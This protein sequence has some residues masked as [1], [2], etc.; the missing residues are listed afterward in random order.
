MITE[1]INEEEQDE[2]NDAVPAVN[3]ED[4]TEVEDIPTEDADED[5]ELWS[6]Q[7]MQDVL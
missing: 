7:A 4:P 2:G 1:E 5:D 3:E 6:S